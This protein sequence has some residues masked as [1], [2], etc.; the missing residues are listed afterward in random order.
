MRQFDYLMGGAAIAIGLAI[1]V[2]AIAGARWL[3]E[4]RRPQWL[5]EKLGPLRARGVLVLVGLV[6]IALGA[7]ILTGW[8]P[9][10]AQ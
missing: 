6:F 5:A 7:V 8:R 3:M 9:P 1:A 2:S 10:W 4:L